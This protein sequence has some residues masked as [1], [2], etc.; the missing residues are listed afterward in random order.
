M[1][2]QRPVH[3]APLTRLQRSARRRRRWLLFRPPRPAPR[4]DRPS[5]RP[6][7]E[8]RCSP[9]V[10]T[11]GT[12][13]L[14]AAGRREPE[15]GRQTDASDC[16]PVV[17]MAHDTIP[18]C[19]DAATHPSQHCPSFW[20]QSR[21]AGRFYRRTSPVQAVSVAQRRRLREIRRGPSPGP[22]AVAHATATPS[23]ARS[24]PCPCKVCNRHPRTS[25][26]SWCRSS[27][28]SAA[29]RLCLSPRD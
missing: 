25:S 28:A 1:R 19:G 6:W 11:E 2:H 27:R 20:G 3:Q 5:R 12:R 10:I 29:R 17:L 24:R 22:L 15:R 18:C 13:W 16:Q 4:F 8:S 14:G 7:A 21:L 23:V 9:P 26:C